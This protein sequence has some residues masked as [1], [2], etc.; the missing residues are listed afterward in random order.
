MPIWQRPLSRNGCT[1]YYMTLCLARRSEKMG[2]FKMI[3]EAYG[4]DY[5][6]TIK[7]ILDRKIQAAFRKTEKLRQD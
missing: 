6:Q 2:K 3:F 5:N 4:A 1:G 7:R